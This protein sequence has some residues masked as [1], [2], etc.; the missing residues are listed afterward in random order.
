MLASV[1]QGA[2]REIY[3][4]CLSVCGGTETADAWQFH[5]E[6]SREGHD[7]HTGDETFISDRKAGL[8]GVIEA[9]Q[10]NVKIGACQSHLVDNLDKSKYKFSKKALTIQH[11]LKHSRTARDTSNYLKQLRE[12]ISSEA[13]EYFEGSMWEGGSI[14]KS[15][16]CEAFVEGERE[17]VFTTQAAE[18]LNG[19]YRGLGFR[20]GPL[21]EIAERALRREVKI[22]REHRTQYRKLIDTNEVVGPRIRSEVVQNARSCSNLSTFDIELQGRGIALVTKN[23]GTGNEQTHKV[24]IGLDGSIPTCDCKNFRLKGIPCPEACALI[25]RLGLDPCDYVRDQLKSI[26]G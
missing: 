7:K 2:D 25:H 6:S 26:S 22:L 21:A 14:N 18:S 11:K 10:P 12:D 24:N 4:K 5:L 16:Q 8:V 3:V 17:G 9:V 15:N 19:A 23:S 13:W 20:D 1:F